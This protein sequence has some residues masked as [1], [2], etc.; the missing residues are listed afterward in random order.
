MSAVCGTAARST[1]GG[2]HPG[3]RR[4]GP[5][6][7]AGAP[8]WAAP[9][10]SSA[11]HRQPEVPLPDDARFVLRAAQV[12]RQA[13][14][15]GELFLGVKLVDPTWTRERWEQAQAALAQWQQQQGRARWQRRGLEA[16]GATPDEES[17]EGDGETVVRGWEASTPP[18]QGRRPS[19]NERDGGTRE[20]GTRT[21]VR[22]ACRGARAVTAI[23]RAREPVAQSLLEQRDRHRG[24]DA[25]R[26]VTRPTTRWWVGRRHPCV[27]CGTPSRPACCSACC[28]GA[29]W[30]GRAPRGNGSRRPRGCRWSAGSCR[31][32]R[33][34]RSGSRR[35]PRF[36]RRSSFRR[37][38]ASTSTPPLCRI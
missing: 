4:P 18:A 16:L 19:H 29:A 7:P 5:S 12:L 25:L 2:H 27:R 17:K 36:R 38:G 35:P 24:D 32:P 37:C 11:A 33:A 9:R 28:W 14:W 20:R 22:T 13:G 31:A 6:A 10:M 34:M 15:Q 1:L 30:P 21:V 3:G 8:R 23:P 26:H